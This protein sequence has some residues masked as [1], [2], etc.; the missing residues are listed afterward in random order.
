MPGPG[1]CRPDQCSYVILVKPSRQMTWCYV[2]EDHKLCLLLGRVMAEA[3]MCR[4]LTSKFWVRTQTTKH[5]ICD[6]VQS[7]TA[8]D[9]SPSTS[10][11]PVIRLRL[12]SHS[13]I[14]S[15][16]CI[17][18]LQFRYSLNKTLREANTSFRFTVYSQV[19]A[20]GME[21]AQLRRCH[22]VNQDAISISSSV[23]LN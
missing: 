5:E 15:R 19:P 22:F 21:S 9:I 10:V 4:P 3:A 20:Y 7:G 17:K 14:H 12:Y 11:F 6:G 13:L 1:L 18:Y 2:K 23:Q 16:R 8:I